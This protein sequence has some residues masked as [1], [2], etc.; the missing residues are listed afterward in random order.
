MSRALRVAMEP[1]T[2]AC[3]LC[4]TPLHAHVLYVVLGGAQRT[5]FS[6]VGPPVFSACERL[7]FGMA[8]Q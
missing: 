5:P 7:G 1:G 3:A 2:L 8:V 4:V 6:Q